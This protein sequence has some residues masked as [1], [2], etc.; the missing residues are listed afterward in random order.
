MYEVRNLAFSYRGRQVLRDVSFVVSPGEIVSVAGSNGAGKTTLLKILATVLEPDS[1]RIFVEGA[2]ALARPVKYRR[3]LG[4]MPENPALYGDMT[5]KSYLEYRAALKGE[6][7]KRIRRRVSEAVE[8]CQIGDMLK[9]RIAP[10]SFG[11][12]RRVSFADA[13]LMRP[14]ILLL[15]DFLAGLDSSAR[16][17]AGAWLS[18]VAAFSSVV[19]TGHEIEDF[20]RW[21]T[22]ILV[23]SQGE[24]SATVEAAGASGDE[25]VRRTLAA[26]KGVNQ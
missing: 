22:R 3:Q 15:D 17:S 25:V 9:S 4:Y 5:V 12:K 16:E 6:K 2:D 26:L 11:M 7:D 18:T 20:A 14:K 13:I 1:G 23:L 8:I 21:S 19:V 10:L 24:V